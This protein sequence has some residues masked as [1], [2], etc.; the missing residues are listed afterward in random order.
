MAPAPGDQGFEGFEVNGQPIMLVSEIFPPRTGGSGRWFWEI[1][2]R[3]PR[4]DFRIVAG[5]HPQQTEFDQTHDLHVTRFADFSKQR[6][7][8]NFKSLRAYWRG[9]RQLN[10]L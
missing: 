5:E 9:V 6:V 8:R 3:L 1:Y 4:A 2:R 7:V 10:A